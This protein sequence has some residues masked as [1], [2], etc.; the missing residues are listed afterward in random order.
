MKHELKYFGLSLLIAAATM[1]VALLAA[2]QPNHWHT[3]F[4]Q[5]HH[6]HWRGQLPPPA[7]DFGGVIEETAADSKP[8]WPPRVVPPKGTTN[9]LL[10]TTDDQGYGA[11]GTFGGVIPTLT[12]DRVGTV[13]RAMPVSPTVETEPAVSSHLLMSA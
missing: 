7:G 2:A 4:S 9:V 5:H 1:H 8:Y 10:I 3:W 13:L 11:S 12:L 6:D